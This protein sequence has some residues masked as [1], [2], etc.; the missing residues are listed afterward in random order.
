MSVG[1]LTH[2]R[3]GQIGATPLHRAVR[4]RCAA[5]VGFYFAGA[6]PLRKNLPGSTPFHLAVRTLAAAGRVMKSQGCTAT[7]HRNVFVEV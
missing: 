3:A 5:A 1:R 7:D 6:D 2:Q 4:A